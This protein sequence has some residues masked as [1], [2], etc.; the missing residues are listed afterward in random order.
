MA[1]TALIVLTTGVAGQD[2]ALLRTAGRHRH[3]DRGRPAGQRRGV[4]AAASTYGDR[5][6]RR[7][8]RPVG[9]LLVDDGGRPRR[10][11]SDE[12]VDGWLER[13]RELDDEVEH[14]WALVRQASESA[15][16]NPRRSAGPL[17]D[18]EDWMDTPEP[19]RAGGG[20]DPQHAA[21]PVPAAGGRRRVEPGLPRR[22]PRRPALGGP[23]DRRGGA[24][25]DPG[26][27]GA[28]RRAWSPRWTP[29]R[30]PRCG[31]STAACSS[32]CATSST[33]WTRWRLPTRWPAATAVH[34][35]VGLGS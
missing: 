17:R 32:P 2:I 14:A 24:G 7:A 8:G 35:G 6:D 33:R 27:P 4:A 9:E 22:V 28:A 1:A 11:P 25:L 5:G 15:R 10:G 21:H 34:A 19:D 3:R 12:D 30:R 31:R 29:R 23:R 20:R 16:L 26:L 18:P 13:T